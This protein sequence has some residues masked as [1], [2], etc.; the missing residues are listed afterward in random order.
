MTPNRSGE[1][2]GAMNT[3]AIGKLTVAIMTSAWLTAPAAADT[4]YVYV[5]DA[6]FTPATLNI[7]VGDTVI[8]VNNDE[9][10]P[11]HTTTSDLLITDPDY[12]YGLLSGEGDSYTNTFNN[13]G[14]FTYRDDVDL[15]T[16]TITVTAPQS[17]EIVLQSPRTVGGQFL[18]DVSGLTPGQ[19]NVV[20]ASTNLVQWTGVSTNIATASSMTITNTLSPG[21]KLF[22]VVE[23]N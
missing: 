9:L 15:N 23:L 4:F 20:Q 18:F 3:K 5:D 10:F 7:S 14:T 16:G 22:R 11:V 8:W 1:L 21:A 19:T 13:P 17:Q 6:G 12:W 2:H